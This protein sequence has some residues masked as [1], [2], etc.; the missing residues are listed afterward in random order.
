MNTVV[1]QFIPLLFPR[2][3]VFVSLYV[4]MVLTDKRFY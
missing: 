4:Y 3:F 2:I 1:V